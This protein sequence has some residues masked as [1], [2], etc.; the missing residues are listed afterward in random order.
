MDNAESS[1]KACS[2]FGTSHVTAFFSLNSL[3]CRLSIELLTR[4]YHSA[5]DSPDGE[6]LD[7]PAEMEHQHD[8]ARL[9]ILIELEVKRRRVAYGGDGFV[10]MRTSFCQGGSA[11]GKKDKSSIFHVLIFYVDFWGFGHLKEVVKWFPVNHSTAAN[12]QPDADPLDLQ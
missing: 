3:E 5:S 7:D 1:S 12:Y 11:A 8:I 9:P 10:R 6:G 2:I 4:I